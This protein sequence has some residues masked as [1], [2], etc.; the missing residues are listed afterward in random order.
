MVKQYIIA[1]GLSI[2]IRIASSPDEL[3]SI[4]IRI[5]A[6]PKS[7]TPVQLQTQESII[8][9]NDHKSA[10]KFA[11][12]HYG[13]AGIKLPE[14]QKIV[15]NCK[16]MK[17][18]S[19]FLRGVPNADKESLF[20]AVD[21]AKL[22]VEYL[23]EI[24][25]VPGADPAKLER[26]LRGSNHTQVLLAWME[27]FGVLDPLNFT[28]VLKLTPNMD[29]VL[30][31]SDAPGYGHGSNATRNALIKFIREYGED[32]NLPRTIN[33]VAAIGGYTM[34]KC[35]NEAIP[36]TVPDEVFQKAAARFPTYVLPCFKNYGFSAELLN[37]LFASYNTDDKYSS[38]TISI[39]NRSHT[40]ADIESFKQ[41]VSQPGVDKQLA[42]R[43]V[44]VTVTVGSWSAD[45][46]MGILDI[47]IELGATPDQIWPAIRKTR[48]E[49][50]KDFFISKFPDFDTDT[51]VGDLLD[52][53]T[54]EL[55]T[56]FVKTKDQKFWD[57]AIRR[58]NIGY[59]Q[60]VF[61]KVGE[62][63]WP[64]EICDKLCDI[65]IAKVTAHP[66]QSLYVHGD[67]TNA[68]IELTKRVTNALLENIESDH[69]KVA[70]NGI[71]SNLGSKL[72][73]LFDTWMGVIENIW[74]KHPKLDILPDKNTS[75]DDFI[76]FYEV[77][78]KFSKVRDNDLLVLI[79]KIKETQD[80]G[81]I[82]L[83]N[84]M[85]EKSLK[86]DKIYNLYTAFQWAMRP[87]APESLKHALLKKT[88]SAVYSGD[89]ESLPP[90]VFELF[91]D[92]PELKEANKYV[93]SGNP[94]KTKETYKSLEHPRNVEV[95]KYTKDLRIL[96]KLLN[97]GV[98]DIR[99]LKKTNPRLMQ[100]LQPLVEFTKG[101]PITDEA[102]TSFEN[103][104][105]KSGYSVE[106]GEFKQNMQ[107]S[108]SRRP[109][110]S[111]VP[112]IVLRVI[113]SDEHIKEMKD[114]GVYKLFDMLVSRYKNTAHP[115][116]V[117]QIG[118][119]R[120][121]VAEDKEYLLVDEVQSD[122]LGGLHKE[123]YFKIKDKTPEEM[124]EMNKKLEEIIDNFPDVA[125][126]VVTAFAQ[127]NG[128]K[129]IFWHTYEG[130]MA[131][132][133]N[134]PPE[135]LY[136]KTPKENYFE[137]TEDQPFRLPESFWV[138]EATNRL[139][140]SIASRLTQV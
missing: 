17:Y 33:E 62:K 38:L 131:L 127:K 37:K 119:I 139:V 29:Y 124:K 137:V 68:P 6:K 125:T 1:P 58:F 105:K 91:K 40:D 103:E 89:Q 96:R 121:D 130:G 61:K 39:L 5:A 106:R 94:K 50:L 107:R 133:G 59:M 41:L 65:L 47:V 84:S 45:Y 24:A 86:K 72:P 129:R 53:S 95:H 30:Y 100:R 80:P 20:K 81:L 134:Q 46:G 2:P 34:L 87:D 55:I 15:E 104:L 11:R 123:Y 51:A 110:H 88:E 57:E 128:I 16:S 35:I 74:K 8:A 27:K 90:N 97:K 116:A 66:E 118:W 25:H 132:K 9:T 64:D 111:D 7:L 122:V 77:K 101:R 26:R 42:I 3:T 93:Q 71:M 140:N 78:N 115:Y 117:N 67:L 135:S 49:P 31:E 43:D 4:A 112:Q 79:T 14:L 92:T 56:K 23:M 10:T 28:G 44:L 54:D 12:S 76:K 73:E 136:K 69:A 70:F 60:R 21:S 120:L 36:D 52:L 48:N 19:M 63:A 113:A 32:L 99:E 13:K 114:A 85:A 108:L 98:R 22:D 83:A 82:N 126:E 102:L 75:A 138:R 109:S 18:I